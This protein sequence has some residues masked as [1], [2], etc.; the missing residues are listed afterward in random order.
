MTRRERAEISRHRAAGRKRALEEYEAAGAAQADLTI[1]EVS[2]YAPHGKYTRA[3]FFRGYNAAR[4]TG[5]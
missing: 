1:E 5:D 2:L 3:A 4:K